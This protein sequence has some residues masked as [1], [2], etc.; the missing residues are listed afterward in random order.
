[1]LLTESRRLRQNKTDETFSWF[2]IAFA[3]RIILFIVDMSPEIA[4][5]RDR[6]AHY[7]NPRLIAL[8]G[9][10]KGKS[11]GLTVDDFSIGR[12][13]SNSLPLNDAL[14]S[15]RHAQV[16][17]TG[18]DVTIIDLNSRNG[19]FVNAVPIKERK[20]EPGDRIQIGDSLLLF[21]LEEEDAASPSSHVRFDETVA[22]GHR[23]VQLHKDDSLYLNPLKVPAV[24]ERIA[25]DLK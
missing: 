22:V 21:M 6:T 3:G 8:A 19:T 17:N 7:M 25:R 16:R 24:T 1:M 12:D 18:C 14:I 2:E 20:L 11:F 5:P 10:S 9:P 4:S 15:R 13:P 23:L